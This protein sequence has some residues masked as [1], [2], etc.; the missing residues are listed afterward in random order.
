MGIGRLTIVS[1]GVWKLA[2][3]LISTHRALST[4]DLFA[5]ISVDQLA[6]HVKVAGMARVLL[7]YMEKY[8]RK[9]WPNILLAEAATDSA[10]VAE[11]RAGDDVTGLLPAFV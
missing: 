9:G 10:E 6:D 3:H 5:S 11:P 2:T 7:Q 4:L 1:P 8:P